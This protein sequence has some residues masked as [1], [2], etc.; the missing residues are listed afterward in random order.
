MRRYLTIACEGALMAA[1]LD[2][3]EGDAALLIVSGG[4]ETRS[5]P[6]AAMTRLAL[7]IAA[8]GYP[9]LR[10]DRRGVGDSEGDDPGFDG[11]LPDIAA[12]AAAL[13]A[14]CPAVRRVIGLGTC[15]AAAA[16]ALSHRAA[17]LDALLLVNPWVVPPTGDL[18][19]AAAIRRRYLDRLTSLDGWSRLARGRIDLRK[20][21]RGLRSAAR[22]TPPAP[23]AARVRQGLAEADATVLLAAGDATAQ[24]FA[25]EHRRTPFPAVLHDRDTGSHALIGPGDAEWLQARVLDALTAA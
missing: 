6:H 3:A 1:T 10:F 15:D 9:V 4:T 23:L 21:W 18:P 16:L 25:A 12:A 7:R 11:A 2:P 24:A 8:A 19:P 20:A 17:A 13:R 14:T 22:P 5:G